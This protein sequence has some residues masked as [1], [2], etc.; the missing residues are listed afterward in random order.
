[1][2][3]P[4]A[5]GSTLTYTLT[6]TNVGNGAA[7][8]VTVRDLIPANT[9]YTPGSLR[10]AGASQTDV[11]GDDNSTFEVGFNRAVF[12]IGALAASASRTL[13]YDVTV[14]TPLSN[15]TTT[16]GS[17]ATAT[18]SNAASKTATASITASAS[19]ALTLTKSAPSNV[20]FPLT[21]LAS[22]ASGA[23][24]LPTWEYRLDYA[25]SG[26]APA[27]AV[28]VTDAL[29]PGLTFVSADSG[30]VNASGT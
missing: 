16:I 5:P 27:T 26:S 9:T 20:P 13:A 7:A 14:N 8:G 2:S 18:A 25:N 12:S 24:V 23:T 3:G 30:G 1:P 4:V 19:P 29:A 21:T 22:A 17:T 10:Y 11:S 15:G 6:V 28:V